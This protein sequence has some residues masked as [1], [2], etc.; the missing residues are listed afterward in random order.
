MEN[1]KMKTFA[2]FGFLGGLQFAIGDILVYLLPNYHNWSEIYKDWANMSMLRIVLALYLGCL[3]SVLLLVG[4][5]SFYKA[6][7]PNSSHLI[8]GLF[9]VTA[10][11]V[12]L[13]S[14]GHFIIACLSPMAY[15]L[16]LS[17]GATSDLALLIASSWKTI[18]NPLKL[19]IVFT[20]VLVQS[21][22]IMTLILK[23]RIQ[24][25]KW[26][27]L[28]NPLGLT[29]LSIPVSILLS[30]TGFEGLSEAFESL[31]EAMM[32]LAVYSHWK[33]Q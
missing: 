17:S 3:G 33:H 11:G 31:G 19:F 23:R 27:I 1:K 6:I 2:L 7:A 30:G 25:P 21:L 14:I 22:L 5:Y 20:V 12:L 10:F 15:K 29:L 26:M 32:Y 28:L 9:A 16:A 4:F 8:K 13:T 24:C 18:T